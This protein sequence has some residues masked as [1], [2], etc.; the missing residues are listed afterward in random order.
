MF[1]KRSKATTVA[2]YIALVDEPK[3]SQLKK[4]HALIKKTL[5]ALRPEVGMGMIG[6]GKY[7]Y[8]YPSGREGD[9][10]RVSMASNKTGISV[11]VN[12]VDDAGYIA[13]QARD[14][15]GKASVGKSCIRFR[16]LDD[17][18]LPALTEVLRRVRKA[19]GLGE[20]S[21]APKARRTASAVERAAKR[22]TKRR[23]ATR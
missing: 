13:E 10:Y 23:A 17:I 11:Y 9:C 2:G 21:A 3:R 5:P 4:L 1:D 8:R 20:A 16:T 14:R 15:L 18:H 19:P 12:A 7:H 6:Y 22:P